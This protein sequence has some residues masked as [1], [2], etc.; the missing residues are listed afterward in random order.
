[1][2]LSAVIFGM[3]PLLARIAYANGSNAYT[4]AF[5]R[6]L[7]GS[8]FLGII[9]SFC[10][11]C[12]IA[13]GRRQL[14]ELF[15]LSV[16]YALTPVLLYSSYRYIDVGMAT[17]L[18]FTYP[19][20]VMIIMVAFFKKKI[21]K[22]QIVCAILCLIG[23][24]FLANT[25]GN[26]KPLGILLAVGS[27]VVY[28]IYI[29]LLGR[30]GVGG[31]HAFTRVFWLVIFAALESGAIALFSGELTISVGGAGWAAELAMALFAT[32]FGI[33]CFQK[34]VFLCGE[35]KASL[36][37]TFEPITGILVGILAFHEQLT[38][39]KIL[40]IISVLIAV[41]LLVIPAEQLKTQ[42]K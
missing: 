26:T 39:N 18:H 36:L 35:V 19:V 23:M 30:S 20:A 27:G 38:G 9:I 32:V 6:F 10:P 24:A 14:L 8:V 5:F 12:G 41:I 7:F 21:D 31:L 3:M 2:V 25:D 29:V 15:M 4:V 17:T 34:G 40:G 11:G 22:R 13:V 1:M 16:P 37:S 28:A 33:V 42:K